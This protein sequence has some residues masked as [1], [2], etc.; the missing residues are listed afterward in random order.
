MRLAQLVPSE[1]GTIVLKWHWHD[2]SHGWNWHGYPDVRIVQLFL[3]DADKIVTKSD[4]HDC[5]EVGF[6]FL[7]C[8]LFS[9]MFFVT[10]L[11]WRAS[12]GKD[13]LIYQYYDTWSHTFFIDSTMETKSLNQYWALINLSLKKSICKVWIKC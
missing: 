12:L 8:I 3:S 7:S 10:I 6:D 5:F 2:Y 4:Q 11:Q 1:T 13:C 9:N